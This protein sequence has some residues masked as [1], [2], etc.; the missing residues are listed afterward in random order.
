MNL[1][2]H[3]ANATIHAHT[4]TPSEL[5]RFVSAVWAPTGKPAARPTPPA[6]GK[7]WPGQGGNYIC[8]LPALLGLRERHLIAGDGEVEDLTYGPDIDVPGAYSRVDGAASTAALLATG[9]KHPA[10]EWARG[11]TADGHTDFFLPSQLDLFMAS[12]CAAHLFK[13]SGWY[14]SSTQHSR[15]SAFVQ[16][17]EYG[18]STWYNKGTDYRVRAFR[19]IP[20][21]TL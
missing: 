8:T 10:A 18:N 2:I 20:T 9:Q 3:I 12:I 11:Y 19:A 1:H 6:S 4:K 5:Q 7:Y 16:G 15:V 14:R 17:F 21:S 13:K